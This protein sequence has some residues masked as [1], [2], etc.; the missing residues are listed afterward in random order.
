MKTNVCL[1][2]TG[3]FITIVALTALLCPVPEIAESAKLFS[4]G[5]ALG[6]G[7]STTLDAWV[8]Q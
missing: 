7:I 2:L 1:I 4:L 3:L 6:Y 8:K 5:L